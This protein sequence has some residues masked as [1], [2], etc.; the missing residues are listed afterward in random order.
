[1]TVAI[2]LS[3]VL[4]DLFDCVA[5]SE[6]TRGKDEFATS[7][8]DCDKIIGCLGFRPF[9]SR[10]I[11]NAQLGGVSDDPQIAVVLIVVNSREQADRSQRALS[12]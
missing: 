12:E 11:F 3:N 1:M 6:V 10:M 5:S 9:T 2:S 8:I 4:S 7:Q